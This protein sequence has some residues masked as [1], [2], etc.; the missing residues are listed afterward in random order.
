MPQRLSNW[1]NFQDIFK[2][3]EGAGQRM[4]DAVYGGVEE[5]AKKARGQ[6]GTAAKGFRTAASSAALDGLAGARNVTA[7]QAEKAG[8]RTYTG[9]RTLKEYDPNV[10][11]Q[12]ADA[13]QR[14]NASA[15]AQYAQTYKNA[16]AGGSALDQALMG[17]A[18]GDARRDALQGTF[19]NLLAELRAEQA[20]AQQY[21]TQKSGQVSADAARYAGMVPGLR[22]SEA[23]AKRAAEDRALEERN[24][25]ARAAYDADWER[26]TAA[27]KR[28]RGNQIQAAYRPPSSEELPF[29]PVS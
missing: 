25:A 27:F 28:R 21:G 4:N 19:G 8:Q 12:V 3:N 1:V 24:N 26:R 6:L 20:A 10:G 16:S 18:G 15:G 23:I 11:A 14:V 7:D 9:P 2:A 5:D 13:A 29:Y 22:E 17:N